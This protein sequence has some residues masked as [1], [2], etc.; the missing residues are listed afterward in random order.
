MKEKVVILE[1]CDKSGKSTLYQ[2]FRRATAYQILIIDRWVGSQIV[3][4]ELYG[5]EDKSSH[6]Y[7]HEL[8]MQSIYD[9][10]LVIVEASEDTL[11]SRIEQNETGEDLNIALGNFQRAQAGFQSYLERS[12]FRNK[13]TINTDQPI[14][15]CVSQMLDFI[16]EGKRSDPGREALKEKG[17]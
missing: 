3:Y 16:G 6:W 7:Q 10:Y 12:Q 9:V 2:A 11:R 4:D 15:V 8:E 1:G 5:R 14:D 17:E 13:T